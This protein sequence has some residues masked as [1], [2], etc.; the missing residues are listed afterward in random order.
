[1]DYIN[2]SFL[3]MIFY[4]NYARC[5]YWERLKD[6]W[7]LLFLTIVC[8]SIIISKTLKKIKEAIRENECETGSEGGGVQFNSKVSEALQRPTETHIPLVNNGDYSS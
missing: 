1:M 6:R 3:V 5:S 8:E 2:V 4:Y 7:N